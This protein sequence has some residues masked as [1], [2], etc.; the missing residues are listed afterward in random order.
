MNTDCLPDGD[1]RKQDRKNDAEILLLDDEPLLL[2]VLALALN[3][4]G[5]RSITSCANAADALLRLDDAA[6]PPIELIFCDLNMPGM[7]G[8]QF[9]RALGERGWQGSLVLISGEER[10]TVD[11]VARL[12]S[13]HRLDLLGQMPKPVVRAQL[14]ELLERW[15]TRQPAPGP[16]AQ[17]GEVEPGE[18]R[19]ALAAGEFVNVYQPKMAFAGGGIEGV[20]ALVRW[21]HPLA[22]IIYPDRFIG[23]AERHGLIDALTQAVCARA[24]ADASDWQRQGL[25]L[26]VAINVSMDS[27]RDLDFPERIAAEV[28]RAAFNP[29]QLVLELTESRLPPNP[30]VL[31]DTLTRLRLKRYRLSIDDFGTGYSTLAQLRDI[32]FDE[33]KIDRGFVHRAHAD[34]A[35]GAILA[36]S[37]GMAHQLG[38]RTV[39]EGIEDAA[40][41]QHVQRLGCDLGQGYHIARPMPPA[42]LPA[43]VAA[44]SLSGQAR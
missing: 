14:V 23:V 41:W 36:A 11:T 5:Y 15:R 4:C 39:A 17:A 6:L 1:D 32:P 20:E 33:L 43:W 25:G 27:L 7:D 9:V 34:P 21:Q 10:R 28:R 12:A 13:A 3:A 38:L 2:R 29:A 44:R 16:G 19:R 35:R 31:L 37:L 22:G 40:D 24:L 30:V 26:S 42:A 8:V 18:L